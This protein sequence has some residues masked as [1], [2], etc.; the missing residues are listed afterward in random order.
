MNYLNL[1]IDKN[2]DDNGDLLYTVMTDTGNR[3]LSYP[4]GAYPTQGELIRDVADLIE[5]CG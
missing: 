1:I 3:V 4:L 5:L 2:V